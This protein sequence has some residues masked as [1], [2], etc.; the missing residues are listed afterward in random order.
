M[1]RYIRASACVLS[2]CECIAGSIAPG[3]GVGALD[4]DDVDWDV[5]ENLFDQ[6]RQEFT[7]AVVLMANQRRCI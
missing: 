4:V 7:M 6:V 5:G 1:T 2:S 3:Y